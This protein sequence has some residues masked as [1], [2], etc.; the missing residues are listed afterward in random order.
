MKQTCGIECCQARTGRAQRNHIGLAISTWIDKYLRK[1]NEK[2]SFYQ[3]DW[4]VIKSGISRSMRAI[5]TA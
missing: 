4:E 3:Q 1:V 5:L 2:I